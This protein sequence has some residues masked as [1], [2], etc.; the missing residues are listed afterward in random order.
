MNFDLGSER[1][2]LADMVAR[3]LANRFP[4]AV[5]N[6][7]AYSREGHSTELWRDFI[8]CGVVAALFH[9]ADGGL[10]GSGFDIAAVFEPMGRALVVEPV[11]QALL[12]GRALAR[13]GGQTELIQS[14]IDGAAILTFAHEEPQSRY[15]LTNVLTRAVAR[16]DGWDLV[17]HKSVVSQ[18]EMATHILVTAR[19][20]GSPG[21]EQGLSLFVVE[22][23]VPGL[24][25]RTYGLIDGGRGG[26][27]RLDGVKASLVG[28]EGEA[29]SVIEEAVAA[30][31][32]ALSWEAI[33][34]IE[35]MKT[36]TADYLRTRSQFGKPIGAF[37]ALR[38]RLATLALEAEQARSAA[39]NA[40]Q[41]LDGPRLDR[42]RAVSAAKYTISVA[43][44]LVAEESLQM[45]G[46]IGLAWE[47]PIAHHAKRLVMLGHQLGDE[48]HHLA[49]Y[50][51]HRDGFVTA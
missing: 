32:V 17:G 24:S 15:D 21:D 42:E 51:A 16:P 34:I 6:R 27:L 26:E 20:S 12:A 18:I 19:T 35:E 33:G 29:F 36:A 50:I 47:A 48:D 1:R 39:I 9:E 25:S 11:L 45:H 22:A 5:R 8:E 3:L 38:H 49:R 10:G 44:R 40:S 23:G 41:A 37:Q 13:S 43:G 31:I 46:G 7:V 4:I 14:V 30:G 28:R 2:M